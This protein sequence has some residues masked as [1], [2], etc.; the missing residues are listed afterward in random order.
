MACG[1]KFDASLRHAVGWVVFFY[2]Y[3]FITVVPTT[4]RTECLYSLGL[5]G[6]ASKS[7]K[8]EPLPPPSPRNILKISCICFYKVKF[9]SDSV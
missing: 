4:H 9:S 3:F 1:L 2:Y 8:T 5:A 6:I 7:V